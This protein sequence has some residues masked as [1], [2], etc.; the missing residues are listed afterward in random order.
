MIDNWH[1]ADDDHREELLA[2]VRWQRHHQAR[3]LRHPDSR[4][5]DHPGCERCDNEEYDDD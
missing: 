4:D 5:P 2:E 1:D 3:L